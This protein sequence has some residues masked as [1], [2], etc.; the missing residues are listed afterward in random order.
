MV[1][2]KEKEQRAGELQCTMCGKISKTGIILDEKDNLP[3]NIFHGM[4][5]CAHCSSIQERNEL[6][7]LVRVETD[8]NVLSIVI[9]DE[10]RKKK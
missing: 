6:G 7:K 1:K 2:W 5:L 9:Y 8:L 3:Y 10:H 4:F